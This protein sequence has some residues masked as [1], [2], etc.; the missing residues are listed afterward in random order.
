MAATVVIQGTAA[1][2]TGFGDLSIGPIS[3]TGTIAPQ[4]VNTVLASG[5]NTILIPTD[6]V[7]VIITPPTASAIA[8][9][10]QGI[11]AD[12]GI[13]IPQGTP[14]IFLFDLLNTPASF[15]ITA[16]SLTTGQ[17][18]FVFF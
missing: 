13:N 2:V 14:S 3:I 16:A 17:T 18:Q 12:T 15:V 11:A 6:S 9:K 10:L 4:V 1:V 7:G 8:L 5:A